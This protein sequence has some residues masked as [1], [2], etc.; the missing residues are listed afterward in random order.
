MHSARIASVAAAALLAGTAA[1]AADPVATATM[2]NQ[3]QA[4][5]GTVEIFE[6]ADGLL[7]R[8]DLSELETG[9]HGFHIHQTGACESDFTS[10]GGHYAPDDS[11]HGFYTENGGHAGDLPNIYV[12]ENGNAMA[13]FHTTRVTLD[14]DTAPLMDDD[15]SAIMVHADPDTYESEAG[16]GDRVA[17]GV[18]EPVGG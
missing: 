4:E 13:D 16:A 8:A 17:C 15:G 18:V 7:L 1:Q 14:G 11:G 9:W 12:G 3:D 10:A 5:I 6:T 2:M